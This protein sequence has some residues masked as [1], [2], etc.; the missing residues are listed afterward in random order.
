AAT[1]AMH[2]PF[3]NTNG[4]PCPLPCG[5]VCG[6]LPPSGRPRLPR[7][8]Y[9][10]DG[11]DYGSPAGIASDGSLKGIDPRD[12]VMRF[13]IGLDNR[14]QHRVL[15]S[16]LVCVY[17]PRFAEVRVS[18]GTNE[19]VEVHGASINQKLDKFAMTENRS[20]ARRLVQNQAPELTR[21]RRRAQGLNG[22]VFTG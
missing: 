20:Y 3:V 17:A 8:E 22:R 9:L 7:D 14:L 19:A 16:N 10:C 6:T 15:P 1:G 21:E 2:C 12:A 4:D 18:T 13:D 11:G 5:P